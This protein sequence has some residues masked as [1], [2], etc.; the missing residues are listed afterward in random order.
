MEYMSEQDARRDK[1]LETQDEDLEAVYGRELT[2]P[3]P[4]PI[5][6]TKRSDFAPWH[7]PV[8]QFVRDKQWVYLTMRLIEKDWATP[9]LVLRYFTLP[10][11]DLLDVRVL[12]E[13]CEPLGVKIEYFGFD[14]GAGIGEAEP[15]AGSVESAAG[16]S[17]ESALRQAGRITDNSLILPD[18]L[19]DIVLPNSQAATQ[20]KQKLPF[21]VINVDACSHL[22][23]I[24]DGQKHSTFDALTELLKHQLRA[25]KPWLLF[26]TT[27]VDPNFIN[28]P[29]APLKTAIVQNLANARQDFGSAL[30]SAIGIEV[31]SLE[32]ML[33]VAWSQHNEAF[34]KLYTIGLSKYLLL[35]FHGQPNLSAKVEL[36]SAYAYRV[37]NEVPDMVALAFRVTPNPIQVHPPSVGGAVGISRLE[38][39]RAIS[40]TR[41]AGEL[42]DLDNALTKD[43]TRKEAVKNTIA[44]L[45]SANYDIPAW[46][47]WLANLKRRPIVLPRPGAVLGE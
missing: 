15:S 3:A 5:S 18:R 33:E 14:S 42:I 41:K 16:S 12:A 11:R 23:Y 28:I 45:E 32:G 34:V 25:Q 6:P 10:G 43:S 29:N 2:Q 19:E 17:A 47:H 35:F 44:L 1:D 22:A 13:S 46:Y 30:A 27:R 26:I 24:S 9:S 4:I 37:D 40:V 38:P 39:S 20:L 8:K 21:H 31:T 36:A 7:H